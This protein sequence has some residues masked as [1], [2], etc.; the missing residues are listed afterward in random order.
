MNDS[1]DLWKILS[2][3][4]CRAPLEKT[5]GGASCRRCD[6]A[7]KYTGSG[8]LDLRLKRPKRYAAELTLSPD[9]TP[10]LAVDFR[11]LQANS[12]PQVDFSS[13]PPP[14]KLTKELMSCFPKAAGPGSLMLDLGC[15]N[16]VHKEACEHCGFKYVGLDYEDPYAPLLGDAHALPF[17]DN[18]FEFILSIAVF[19]HLRYPFVAM[20]EAYRILKP[21]GSL[22]GTVAFL[23]PFHQSY[24][25][26]TH[27]GIASLLE[28][29]GFQVTRVAPSREW[30]V[31]R[32]LAGMALFPRMPGAAAKALVCPL[33]ALHRLWWRVG[34]IFSDQAT[35]EVRLR[36]TTGAFAFVALKR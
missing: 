29:A 9:R 4:N 15:G 36:N 2:C 25:H 5:E 16:T 6:E 34:R 27:W 28:S 32:A 17:L 26:L 33:E 12:S 13:F 35:E 19:E 21:G 18:S 23:E 3:P 7:Y 11:P 30:S 22:I 24:F 31:L 20:C 14:P 10:R 8:V 1:P